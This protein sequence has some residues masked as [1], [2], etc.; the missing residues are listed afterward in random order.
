MKV[1][2]VMT[3]KLVFVNPNDTILNVAKLMQHHNIGCVP[4]VEN[5]NKVLGMIT[6]RDIVMNMAKFNSDPTNTC[7]KEI[8]SDIV[9]QIKPDV[10]VKYALDLMQKQRVRRL[11][12]IENNCLVGIISLGDIAVHTNLNMEVGEALIEISRPSKVENV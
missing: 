10:D 12:V 2:E 8:A 9:Y 7:A 5:Q 3:N 6:D 1:S 4:V 11:P